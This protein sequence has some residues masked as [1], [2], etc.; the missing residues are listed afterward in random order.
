MGSQ[1]SA[2]S[3]AEQTLLK[4]GIDWYEARTPSTVSNISVTSSDVDIGG[5]RHIHTAEYMTNRVAADGR[6]E[7]L[8]L[9]AMHGFGT[10]L[11]MYYAALPPLAERWQG[12]V[13]AIDTLGCG[14]SSRPRW[15]LPKGEDCPVDQVLP[16]ARGLER[17]LAPAFTPH[18]DGGGHHTGAQPA[19][20]ARPLPLGPR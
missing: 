17:G 14:L 7:R 19:L 12:R 20:L 6:A 10:G 1:L 18:P 15:V 11:G 8:P 2:L 3:K 5:N 9:V 13:L 16:S 4:V